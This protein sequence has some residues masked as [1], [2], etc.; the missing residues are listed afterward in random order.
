[1]RFSDQPLIYM[2]K[3]LV[4]R[5]LKYGLYVLAACAIVVIAFRW[6]PPPG[7]LLMLERQFSAWRADEP[8]ERQRQWRSW[9]ELPDSLKM[10]VIAAED[11]HFATHHG[12]DTKA[13]WQAFLHNRENASLRGAS[14]ISQ[15]TAKNVFL[16]SGRSWLRKG[17]E[18]WF[19]VL[20]ECFWPKQRI[21]EV[22]LNNAE[23]GHGI[24]G[25]QA[26]AQ[27]YFGV[28]A[29]RLSARQAYL[30][31]A[32][33][34]NPLQRDA[35]NPSPLVQQR[36]AWIERQVRQLGGSAYLEGFSGEDV[37]QP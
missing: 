37:T 24:F 6:L 1:M 36:A 5:L 8:F 2:L 31:A 35:A 30:L 29:D 25:A 3:S 7:S 22:Y 21:L 15:Q 10:A 32:I 9:N 12:F 19:T 17:L 11:Q 4:Q 20:I 16:W 13:I 26:A 23:W 28:D 18:A 27:H 14:T 33:L 34:P